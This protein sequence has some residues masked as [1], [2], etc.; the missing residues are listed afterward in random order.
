MIKGDYYQWERA[1][2]S[3]GFVVI[4]KEPHL[5]PGFYTLSFLDRNSNF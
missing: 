4:D 2:E 3:I 5:V 1:G